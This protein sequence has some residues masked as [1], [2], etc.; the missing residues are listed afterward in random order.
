MA[1]KVFFSFHYQDVI[2]FRANVVRNH[3]SF[4]LSKDEAGFYD[5]SIW[6]EAK[7]ESSLALK[8][9]INKGLINTSNTCVLVG[10]ETYKRPWVRYEIF[11]SFIKGNHLL[12]VHINGI[13]CNKK[14]TKNLGKNPFDFVGLYAKDKDNV[15]LVEYKSNKW[16]YYTEIDSKSTITLKNHQQL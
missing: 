4:K 1:K 11:K 15:D 13:K 6:E 5:S 14:E 7:K 2:D 10:S 16:H 9:L 8:R 3:G 12:A